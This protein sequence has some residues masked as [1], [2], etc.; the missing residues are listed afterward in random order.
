MTLV[1]LVKSRPNG[2]GYIDYID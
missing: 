2:L 1:N